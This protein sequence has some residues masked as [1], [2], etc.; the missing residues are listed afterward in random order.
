M[1]WT[2][3]GS[4]KGP[5]GESGSSAPFFTVTKVNGN[6]YPLFCTTG[7]LV[8]QL[9]PAVQFILSKDDWTSVSNGGISNFVL[10]FDTAEDAKNAA[11]LLSCEYIY[12]GDNS[13]P[14]DILTAVTSTSVSSNTLYVQ[15][16]TGIPKSQYVTISFQ[17]LNTT[18]I[19]MADMAVRVED[20]LDHKVSQADCVAYC[21]THGFACVFDADDK[22][23]IT[24]QTDPPETN[25][26]S[27]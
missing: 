15:V 26:P 2:K 5:A 21:N 25:G 1:A 7:R 4:I 9:A 3:Q 23:T 27:A 24:R 10:R 19:S 17:W 22:P 16:E 8:E 6:K 14:D 20:L 18:A 13:V 12:I 11:S